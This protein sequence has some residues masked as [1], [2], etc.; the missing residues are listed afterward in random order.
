MM[1]RPVTIVCPA[2]GEE[3]PEDEKLCGPC[4]HDAR[5]ELAENNAYDRMREERDE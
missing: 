3:K 4:D 1:Q 5:R 2:C